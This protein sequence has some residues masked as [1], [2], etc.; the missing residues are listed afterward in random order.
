MQG[1]AE[2]FN[3]SMSCCPCPFRG[4]IFNTRLNFPPVLRREGV[5]DKDTTF[6]GLD[7][8]IQHLYVSLMSVALVCPFSTTG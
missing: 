7:G 1:I 3:T 5:N 4:T 6:T 8:E 2:G